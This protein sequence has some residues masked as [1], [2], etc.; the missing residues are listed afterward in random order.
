MD[1]SDSYVEDGFFDTQAFKKYGK[2]AID[3]VTEEL[4]QKIDDHEVYPNKFVPGTIAKELPNK[5]PEDAE[6]LENILD[7]TKKFI[8]HNVLSWHH[9]KNFGYMPATLSH[10]AVIADMIGLVLNNP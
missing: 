5:A 1:N 9:P 3:L 8:F 4:I 6:P 10:G 7:D 2:D